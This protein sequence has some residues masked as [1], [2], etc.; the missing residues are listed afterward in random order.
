LGAAAPVP[1]QEVA[2]AVAWISALGPDAVGDYARPLALAELAV[3][4][5]P[6]AAKHNALHTQ[7]ALLYRAGRFREAVRR[8]DEGVQAAGGQGTARDWAFL[9][10]A[11]QRLGETTEA[12]KCLDKVAHQEAKETASPWDKLEN[13]ILRQEAETLVKGRA[14]D[15]KEKEDPR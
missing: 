9:A 10:L 1:P 8:L 7:G 5:A 12:R 6:P 13:E 2:N 4:K 3:S 14:T 11:H 15:S